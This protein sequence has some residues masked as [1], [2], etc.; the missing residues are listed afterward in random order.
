MLKA[1]LLAGQNKNDAA[2]KIMDKRTSNAGLETLYGIQGAMISEFGKNTEDAIARYKKVAKLQKNV[3]LRVTILLGNLYERLGKN[4]NARELYDNYRDLNP[5][6]TMLNR[7]YKRLETKKEP[8][9][10][11]ETVSDG[12]AEALFSLGFAIQNQDPYQAIIFSRLAVY[13]RPTF[14][15][16]KLLLAASMEENNNLKDANNIYHSI[17]KDPHYSWAAR[18]R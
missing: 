14:T 12:V 2:L 5:E 9:P 17:S 16:A 1:W 8:R 4:I 13:L 3:N 15:I 10:S 18:L 6:T 11:N 7:A